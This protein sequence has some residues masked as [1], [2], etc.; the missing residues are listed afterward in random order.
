MPRYIMCM[1]PKLKLAKS[2]DISESI[3]RRCGRQTTRAN[4]PVET[5]KQYCQISLYYPFLD[6]L[7]TEL[8][9]R[10]P[11]LLC[12]SPLQNLGEYASMQG[13][14]ACHSS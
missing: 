13:E 12:T 2:F 14:I 3:P 10:L 8:E 4:H 7:I 6:H 11:P 5:P 1:N 9:S